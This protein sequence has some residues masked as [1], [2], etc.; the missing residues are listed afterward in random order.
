M[1]RD[2]ALG[3]DSPGSNLNLSPVTHLRE[4]LILMV[5]QFPYLR[6]EDS[7]LNS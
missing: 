6:K 1:V 3:P 7:L 5:F 4:F 2:M